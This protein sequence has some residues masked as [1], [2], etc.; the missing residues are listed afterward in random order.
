[1]VIKLLSALKYLG[2]IPVVS[3]FVGGLLLFFVGVKKTL[4][5]ISAVGGAGR[6]GLGADDLIVIEILESVDAFLFGL[7]LFAFGY[8][9][10]SMIYRLAENTERPSWLQ[11]TTLAELKGTLSQVII[12]VLMVT[13]VRIVWERID[14]D[15]TWDLLVLP[16][17]I[18]LLAAS[19]KLSGFR[20]RE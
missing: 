5:A 12:V 1:M 14:G 16:V 15:L 9:V 13:F 3:S 8:G 2:I 10:A 4:A 19:V 20:H 6:G 11:P 18:A 17:S 7:V